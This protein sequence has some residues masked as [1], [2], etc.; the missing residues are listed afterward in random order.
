M[1]FRNSKVLKS[2]F[3]LEHCIIFH[4]CIPLLAFCTPSCF[5]K[6][7]STFV[8]MYIFWWKTFWPPR[9][10]FEKCVE[11]LILYWFFFSFSTYHLKWHLFPFQ[12]LNHFFIVTRKKY[13]NAFMYK[14]TKKNQH[15]FQYRQSKCF[16]IWFF[17]FSLILFILSLYE[18]NKFSTFKWMN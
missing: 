14:E 13:I 10:A 2:Q 6:R 12:Q 9:W 8:K 4:V 1:N 5:I 16:S 15:F 18:A 3:Y 11:C 7:L 17:T